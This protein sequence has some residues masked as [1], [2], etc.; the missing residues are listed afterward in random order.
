VRAQAAWTL[1]RLEAQEFAAEIAAL[2]KAPE[3]A[4]RAHAVEAL[5]I[6]RK[7]AYSEEIAGL[8]KDADPSVRGKAVHAL[9]SLGA[10]EYAREL[11]SLRDDRAQAPLLDE[12]AR[13]WAP[14]GI[15]EA[16]TRA[17]AAWASSK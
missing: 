7:R 16:A 13:D 17:L 3:A 4:V 6:L 1:A 10:R 9:V 15:G 2:L 11:E 14:T 5:G 8:L 12:E